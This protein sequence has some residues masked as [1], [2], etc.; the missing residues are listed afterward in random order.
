MTP[1]GEDD[2]VTPGASEDSHE[3][4][5]LTALGSTNTESMTDIHTEDLPRPEST[6]HGQ[7][8]SQS[9]ASPNGMKSHPMEKVSEETQT[10]V[11]KDVVV[12]VTLVRFLLVFMFIDGII[13]VVVQKLLGR[14]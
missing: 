3:S 12:T 13:I 8:E 7:E 1:G 14:Y 5:A 2:I 11:E 10:R 4:A 6:A 9:A